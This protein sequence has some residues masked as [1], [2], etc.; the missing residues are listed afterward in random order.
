MQFHTTFECLKVAERPHPPLT[1]LAARAH[2]GSLGPRPLLSALAYPE[3]IG[4]NSSFASATYEGRLV[5]CRGRM[6]VLR[7]QKKQTPHAAPHNTLLV[8]TERLQTHQL[9][10]QVAEVLRKEALAIQRTPS[11]TFAPPGVAFPPAP[12]PT[13]P[14]AMAAAESTIGNRCEGDVLYPRQ[15]GFIHT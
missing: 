8:A 4:Y 15:V 14:T 5:D 7:M 11:T 12:A 1:A 13:A 10:A 9:L 3:F 2:R 6:G